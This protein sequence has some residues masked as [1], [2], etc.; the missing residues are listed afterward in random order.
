MNDWKKQSL[1]DIENNNNLSKQEL[2]VNITI[3][4]GKLNDV[5]QTTDNFIKNNPD[6]KSNPPLLLFVS[7]EMVCMSR[8]LTQIVSILYRLEI[9]INPENTEDILKYLKS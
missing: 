6:Y 7:G 1:E 3:K 5:I 4:L 2:L 9:K 8:Y